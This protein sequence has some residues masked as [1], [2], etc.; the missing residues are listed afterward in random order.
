MKFGLFGGP[1]RFGGERDDLDAYERYVD[2]VVEAE[3][4]GFYGAYCVEH[5]FTGVGQVS[6]SLTVLSHVAARTNTIRLGTAVVVVPW[7]NPLLLAEQ[8][9]TLDVLSR[10]RFDLG[11]GRGYRDYEFR[12][13]GVEPSDAPRRFDEAVQVLRK[14]WSSG[15]RFSRGM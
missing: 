2:Q 3:A 13:F 14:A 9:A 10:G 5:H 11:L 4:L 12:G 7:H 6:S 8:V 1:G 15:G